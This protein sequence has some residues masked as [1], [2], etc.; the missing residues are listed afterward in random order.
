MS[1]PNGDLKLV[2]ISR[3]EAQ[4]QFK[5]ES[6][7]WNVFP[8]FKGNSSV[9]YDIFEQINL[10][11]KQLPVQTQEN[12]FQ[13]H[14]KIAKLLETPSVTLDK[15]LRGLVKILLDNIDI[16]Q[17]KYWVDLLAP[18]SVPTV[19]EDVFVDSDE[20]TGNRNRTYIKED[21]RWLVAA[22]IIL[23]LCTP[24]WGTYIANTNKEKG[25]NFKEYFAAELLLD[26]YINDSIPLQKLRLFVIENIPK[27]KSMISAT[28]AAFSEEDFPEW[29][30]RLVIIKKLAMEDLRGHNNDSHL[31]KV[32]FQF[33]KQKL[34]N[35][36]N[37][38][39]GS[40]KE[41]FE[42]ETSSTGDDTNNL[43][44]IEGYKI[45][46]ELSAGDVALIRVSLR[47]P[48]RIAERLSPGIDSKMVF[49]SIESVKVLENS[50]IQKAQKALLQYV[51]KPVSPPSG[52]LLL[53]KVD[54]V[55]NIGVMQAILWRAGWYEL[56][57]LSS[58]IKIVNNEFLNLSFTGVRS[59]IT[60]QQT[61][62]L[63]YLY[64]YTKRP[65]GKQKIVKNQN[66]AIQEIERLTD[67][68]ISNDWKL[69]IPQQW[70]NEANIPMKVSR[71]S[72]PAD[73]RVRI[74]DFVIA[75]AEHQYPF[76]KHKSEIVSSN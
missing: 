10:Y 29:I 59:R 42:T 62:R 2:L 44:K 49:E 39:Y 70:I 56:A 50:I 20:N 25:N 71:Y 34:K 63:D 76:A 65:Q 36:D 4:T 64:P 48:M 47:D 26:S 33:I 13:C 74:A 41:K 60:K 16:H 3:Q 72:A 1:N 31:I 9:D 19:L 54:L 35:V 55:R 40:I 75:I 67:S 6:I 14:K 24:I 7:S 43:S 38:F 17:V 32:I 28:L 66:V 15:D 8:Y 45:R 18:I 30:A 53:N 23:R 68:F 12:I 57:A 61:D 5:G 37:S 52:I 22:S 73:I 69:T 21:Y 27:D 11:L 51:F 58:A 46:Q